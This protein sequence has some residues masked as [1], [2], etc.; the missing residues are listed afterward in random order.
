[1]YT[2]PKNADRAEWAFQAVE[3]FGDLTGADSDLQTKIYDLL[4]DMKHLADREGFDWATIERLSQM[5]YREEVAEE[6]GHVSSHVVKLPNGQ[7]VSSPTNT[8]TKN[9]Q[10]AA[11]YSTAADAEQTA[12]R[13][14]GSKI[15]LFDD[16]AK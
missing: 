7:Y 2:E 8:T 4:A 6:G 5:H 9:V 3:H 10:F 12:K 11:A 13:Y 15:V 1:M 16:E 14:P